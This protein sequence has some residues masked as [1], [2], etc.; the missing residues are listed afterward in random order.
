MQKLVD[1][2]DAKY[3]FDNQCGSGFNDDMIIQELKADPELCENVLTELVKFYL[4]QGHKFEDVIGLVDWA[5]D[6]GLIEQD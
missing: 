2:L 5:R 3:A 4:G 6:N 1:R